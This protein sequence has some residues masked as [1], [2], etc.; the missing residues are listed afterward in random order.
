[1]HLENILPTRHP[2]HI[3]NKKNLTSVKEKPIYNIQLYA[4]VCIIYYKVRQNYDIRMGP[5]SDRHIST[6][7]IHP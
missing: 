5:H 2:N 7:H 4:I 1:M 3:I 6:V